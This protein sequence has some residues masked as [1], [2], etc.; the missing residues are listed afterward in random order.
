[1]RNLA[2]SSRF[3]GRLRRRLLA[4]ISFC[5][6]PL[7]VSCASYTPQPVTLLRIQSAAISKEEQGITVGVTPY[8]DGD[9]NEQTFG[10][11]LKQAGILPLQ[12]VV[13][14]SGTDPIR[15]RKGDFVLRLAEDAEYGPA[16]AASVAARLESSAGVVGWTIAFGLVGY[17]ASSTQQQEANNAR[18]GD[19]RDK[20][21][22]DTLLDSQES[23][24][25]F[26]YFLI[27]E[28][29]NEIKEATLFLKVLEPSTNRRI[30][31][32]LP[33]GKMGKWNVPKSQEER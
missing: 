30:H 23:T 28:D 16:S 10:A 15:L 19:L 5:L 7:A 27:P 18:R 14:N 1:M 3:N 22:K 12:V 8:L 11:D 26:L 24:Q 20:S 2:D 33:L 25:G 6:A 21:L 31:L 4:V 13:R 29:V 17:L 9:R 32:M